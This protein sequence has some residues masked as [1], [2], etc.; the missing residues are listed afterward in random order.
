MT[1]GNESWGN[2]AALSEKIFLR[3]LEAGGNF[4]DTADLYA[5]GKSEE[6]LGE[7]IERHRCRSRVVLATKFNFSGDPTNPNA[8]GNSRKHIFDAVEASLRRLRTDYIDLYWMHAW[9]T[10]TPPEEVA[11]TLTSLIESGKIR[12]YG[13]SDTPAWYVGHVCGLGRAGSVLAP[14]ALQLEYS[15]VVRDI[16]HEFVP[17]AQHLGLGICPWSP[18]ASGLL[19]GKYKRGELKEGRLHA[20]KD[21][22]NPVFDKL[23]ER[24]FDIVDVLVETAQSIDR[25]PAEVALNWITKRPGITSTIIGA[26]SLKQLESN[27]R[28]LETDLPTALVN[29]LEEASRGAPMTPYMFFDG[30]LQR[31]SLG[32]NPVRREPTWFR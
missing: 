13:F 20:V 7:L 18:L 21:S 3:Y 23:T 2:D 8:G 24:N 6:I 25:T 9:D 31:M 10:L 14:I 29:R 1:F 19:T 15:L 28:A 17:A 11:Q 16:E 26:T 32:E 30:P 12:Y 5:G 22:A 4:I 27:L